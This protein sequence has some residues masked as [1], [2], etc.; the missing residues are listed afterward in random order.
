MSGDKVDIM[1]QFGRV[2]HAYA[3]SPDFTS[4][5][6]LDILL[7]LVKPNHSMILLDIATGAGHTA[8]KM[9]PHVKHVTAVDITSEMIDRTNELAASKNLTNVTTLLMDAE[10]LSFSDGLFDVITCRFAPHHFGDVRKFLS[11]IHRVLKP[12]GTFVLEDVSSPLDEEQDK[13]INEINKIRDPT[14]VRSYHSSEWKEMMGNSGFQI[15]SVQNF[16]RR[17]DLETW[18]D[19]A[20][21]N[22]DAKAMVRHTCYDTSQ[23]IRE[24]FEIPETDPLSFT[25]DNVIILS[26]KDRG[27]K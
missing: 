26:Q 20:G 21:A 6:D 22:D 3:S 12:G 9:A 24:H 23:N 27:M 10:S 2:S 15:R 14:H 18:L 8:V 11:E 13:F 4:G 5:D 19:R 1:D 7:N 17:Y 16:R 25:E